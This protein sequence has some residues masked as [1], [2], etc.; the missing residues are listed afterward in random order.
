MV[1]QHDLFPGR[2]AHV[3]AR[4]GLK[5]K[6]ARCR[7]NPYGDG[8]AIIS[9]IQVRGRLMGSLEGTSLYGR[10]KDP[11]AQRFLMNLLGWAIGDDR[12]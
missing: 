10:R 12:R 1:S 7:R 2:P 4:S 3:L 11:V 9:R 8:R 6:H 5:L